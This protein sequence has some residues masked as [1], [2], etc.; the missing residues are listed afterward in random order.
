MQCKAFSVNSKGLFG[1]VKKWITSFA[2]ACRGV[3]KH[4]KRLR[5]KNWFIEAPWRPMT[6]LSKHPQTPPP[7]VFI[8]RCDLVTK[9]RLICA[10]SHVT[11][12][13]AIFIAFRYTCDLSSLSVDSTNKPWRKKILES[14]NFQKEATQA[15]LI[16]AHNLVIHARKFSSFQHA[17]IQ[18]FSFYDCFC[19]VSKWLTMPT[20]LASNIAHLTTFDCIWLT[21]VGHARGL[22]LPIQFHV[23]NN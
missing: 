19:F 23:F 20:K 1:L 21:A 12:Q 10:P 4:L 6:S 11:P 18:S 2:K 5:N 3:I 22:S 13:K 16:C 17:P 7:N 15:N 14:L 9:K 8:V